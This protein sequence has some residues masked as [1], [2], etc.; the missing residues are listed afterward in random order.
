MG[1]PERPVGE[2][3]RYRPGLF[4]QEFPAGVGV[5]PRALRETASEGEVEWCALATPVRIQQPCES[6]TS[7]GLCALLEAHHKRKTAETIELAASWLHEAFAGNACGVSF[8][9]RS[10]VERLSSSKRDI[11]LAS[12]QGA[13]SRPFDPNAP[14]AHALPKLYPVSASPDA[15]A[16][17]AHLGPTAMTM[18]VDAKFLDSTWQSRDVY[19]PTGPIEGNHVMCFFGYKAGEYWLAKNSFGPFW[20]DKGWVRVAWSCALRTGF[21]VMDPQFQSLDKL[22]LFR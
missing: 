14:G 18:E 3:F 9:L 11:P 16:A 17:L 8:D 13:G 10:L 21:V 4:A 15:A 20:G 19:R 2:P 22:N 5:F 7:F 1:S 6:C 12:T